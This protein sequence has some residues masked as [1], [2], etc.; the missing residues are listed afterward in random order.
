LTGGEEEAF[1]GFER[2]SSM[3]EEDTALLKIPSDE[4]ELDFE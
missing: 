1:N 2:G 4:E 3:P